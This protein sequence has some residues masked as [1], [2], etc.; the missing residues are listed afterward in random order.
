M[1]KTGKKGFRTFQETR[2]MRFAKA[3]TEHL[4]K[5]LEI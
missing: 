3:N 2:L 4:G 1:W 5:K